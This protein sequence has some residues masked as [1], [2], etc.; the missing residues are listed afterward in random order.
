MTNRILP[1]A[2]AALV[3]GAFVPGASADSFWAWATSLERHKEV[4]P[5]SLPAWTD[6]CSSCHYAYPPGLLPAASW[7][8]LLSPAALGKHFGENIEMKDEVR[9]T[10]LA[11]ATANAADRSLAKRSRK[12]VASLDG[13]APERITETPYICRKHQGLPKQ[14]VQDNPQVK[15]LSQCDACHTEAKTGNLD[16]DTVLIP[17]HGRW[18]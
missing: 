14:L 1:A 16:D 7:Q 8:K 9:R 10:L 17:G 6:E 11:Y 18:R 3:F 5:V 12:L 4:A 15:A 2:A 13:A